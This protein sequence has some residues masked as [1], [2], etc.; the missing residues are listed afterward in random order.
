M[1]IQPMEDRIR[2]IDQ[3]IVRVAREWADIVT[4]RGSLRALDERVRFLRVLFRRRDGM[5]EQYARGGGD[6]K[7]LYTYDIGIGGTGDEP[8]G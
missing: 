6:V 4:A 7:G 8:K 2:D 1:E 3:E 5:L